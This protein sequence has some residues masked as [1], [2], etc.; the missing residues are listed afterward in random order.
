MIDPS[1]NARTGIPLVRLVALVSLFVC[2]PI[3]AAE[4]DGASPSADDIRIL[5]RA[6]ELLAGEKQW[7]RTDTRE[8]VAQSQTR[9]LFCALHA[10]S[11]EVLGH[12]DHRRPALEEVRLAVQE[13]S[14]GRKFEHRLMDFN[15]HSATTFRDIKQVL[16]IARARMNARI[17]SADSAR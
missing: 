16:A 4:S 10:A 12:Y 9:S 1:R 8:C 6:S 13:A 15:N 2:A 7:D 17:R 5:D 3:F 11:L 14:N